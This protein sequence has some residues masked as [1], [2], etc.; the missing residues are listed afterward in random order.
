MLDFAAALFYFA[1][2]A[3]PKSTS[4]F[5]GQIMVNNQWR[6]GARHCAA[7]AQL[8][9]RFALFALGAPAESTANLAAK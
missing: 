8:R 2:G 9:R 4:N 3:P 7:H 5:S 6:S 1:P